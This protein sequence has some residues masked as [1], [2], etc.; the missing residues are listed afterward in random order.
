MKKYTLLLIVAVAA[1]LSTDS[2][3]P[4]A[5]T[6]AICKYCKRCAKDGLNCGVCKK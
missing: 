1:L 6:Y 2:L 3:R 4:L 5:K